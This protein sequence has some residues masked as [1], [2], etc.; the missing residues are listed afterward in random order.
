MGR[1]LHVI[2][3]NPE[4]YAFDRIPNEL[5]FHEVAVIMS[6]A[7]LASVLGALVPAYR[8]S[9]MSPIEALRWE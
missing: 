2:V 9:R 3:W 7:V 1:K 4:V 8:A 5:Q 6:V